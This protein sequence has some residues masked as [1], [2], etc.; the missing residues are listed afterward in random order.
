[1]YQ[2]ICLIYGKSSPLLLFSSS[3]TGNPTCH[4]ERW[5]VLHL[6]KAATY[7]DGALRTTTTISNQSLPLRRRVLVMV[8]VVSVVS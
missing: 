6:W 1:M 4:C 8:M 2:Y 3:H 7:F 5:T